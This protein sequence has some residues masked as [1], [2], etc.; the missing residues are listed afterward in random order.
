MARGPDPETAGSEAPPGP[1][2]KGAL[3]RGPDPDRAGKEAT[4]YG[5]EARSPLVRPDRAGR[6][7][8]TSGPEKAEPDRAG[9]D[10]PIGPER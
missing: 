3:A 2:T 7:A 8:P 5:P 4:E 1:E 9:R 10:A 6:E